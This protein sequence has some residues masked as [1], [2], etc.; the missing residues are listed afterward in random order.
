ME[1]RHL[2]HG[3]E[4]HFHTLLEAILFFCSMLTIFIK[5]ELKN[6]WKLEEVESYHYQTE[7]ELFANVHMKSRSRM[8]SIFLHNDS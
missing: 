5:I 4:T 7:Y 1:N 3:S 6:S 2:L 8:K